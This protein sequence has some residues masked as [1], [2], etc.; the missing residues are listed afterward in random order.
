MGHFG[1]ACELVDSCLLCWCLRWLLLLCLAGALSRD[2]EGSALRKESLQSLVAS[3]GLGQ[4]EHQ[5]L[6]KALPPEVI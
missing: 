4:L 2:K 1:E 3:W 5:P 6:S